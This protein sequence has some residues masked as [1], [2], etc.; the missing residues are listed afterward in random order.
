MKK[1]CEVCGAYRHQSS[2]LYSSMH[3]LWFCSDACL[4]Q[5]RRANA[6]SRELPA[7]GVHISMTYLTAL[8]AMYTV[9]M[10]CATA[11]AVAILSH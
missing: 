1:Q 8:V 10:A 6:I 5:Y 3:N 7:D 11:V 9:T 2:M 4:D